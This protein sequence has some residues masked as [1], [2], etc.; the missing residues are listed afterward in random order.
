ML[1]GVFCAV[2]CCSPCTLLDKTGRGWADEG[3]RLVSTR[4]PRRA[5]LYTMIVARGRSLSIEQK[6]YC[7]NTGASRVTA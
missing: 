5:G 4:R 6:Q 1:D 7:L 2:E 3:Q